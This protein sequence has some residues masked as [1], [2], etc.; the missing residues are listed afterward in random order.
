MPPPTGTKHRVSSDGDETE[1][2]KLKNVE[3][4]EHGG[5]YDMGSVKMEDDGETKGETKGDE[6]ATPFEAWPPPPSSSRR[7]PEKNTEGWTVADRDS[8]LKS[9]SPN[10]DHT[11]RWQQAIYDSW[12]THRIYTCQ[13]FIYN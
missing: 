7:I 6:K 8:M 2:T 13:P 1:G 10:V 4:T 3:M 12:F 9:V 11:P 5:A